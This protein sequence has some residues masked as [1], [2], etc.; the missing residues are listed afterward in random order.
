MAYWYR[1]ENEFF[2]SGLESLLLKGWHSEISK[3]SELFWVLREV[4]N[5]KNEKKELEEWLKLPHSE[6]PKIKNYEMLRMFWNMNNRG[7]ELKK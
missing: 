3:E 7:N 2:V 5:L 1:G 6:A 4:G